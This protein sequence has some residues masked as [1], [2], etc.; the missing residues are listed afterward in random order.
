MLHQFS[1][2]LTSPALPPVNPSWGTVLHG[3][4]TE[5]LSPRMQE[6][7]HGEGPR[8][9]AQYLRIGEPGQVRWQIN[10]W[11]DDFAQEVT[12]AFQPGGQMMLTQK[13]L[14]LTCLSVT[15]QAVTE[16]EWA[17]PFFTDPQ[18]QRMY[19]VQFHTP[20][21]HKRDGEYLL[22]PQPDVMMRGLWRKME[23]LSGVVEMNDREAMED[24]ARSVAIA[25][26]RMHSTVFHLEGVHVGCFTGKMTMY[27]RG[28]PHLVRLSAMVL[29]F[30]NYAGIG[31]KTSLGMGGCTVSPRKPSSPKAE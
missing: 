17:L 1:L 13:N 24:A 27:L 9:F 26:Y 5:R 31:I 14:P 11:S 23:S 2:T 15:H 22:F 3:M 19:D 4:L 6:M 18:V 28:N 20:C 12:A 25:N 8:P 21:S 7:I 10:T 16:E 30:A 29:N